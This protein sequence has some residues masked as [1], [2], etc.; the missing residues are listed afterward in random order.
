MNRFKLKYDSKINF[1][2]KRIV[3]L[4]AAVVPF[5]AC[6]QGKINTDR[7]TE[8]Q[9]A[10]VVSKGTFQPEVGFWLEGKNDQDHLYQHPNIVLRYGLLNRIELRL[11]TNFETQH[12]RSK[13]E[14]NHGLKPVEVGMKANVVQTKDSS[15]SA[16]LY[17]LL[18]LPRLAAHD[19]RHHETF[20]RARLL[21]ENKL[22]EKIKLNYNI[23][24]DWNSEEKEQNWLYALSPQFELSDKWQ[25]F[26]ESYAT[27]KKGSRPEHYLDGGLGY[28][29]SNKVMLD[30]DAGVGLNNKASDY[31]ITAGI[32]FQL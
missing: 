21:F 11:M 27:F 6:A 3:V 9:S 2:K 10:Q 23:G 20:Y 5:F 4:L 22:T 25:L 12:F 31:F 16:T 19:Y 14:S 30:V 32:S 24:R 8:A 13:S 28:F 17:G 7:P 29:I 15:F 1:M 26:L 18:G